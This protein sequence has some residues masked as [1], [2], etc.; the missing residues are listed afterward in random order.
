MVLKCGQIQV[1]VN[2]LDFH[3]TKVKLHLATDWQTRLKPAEC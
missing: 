3:L 1:N 2:L